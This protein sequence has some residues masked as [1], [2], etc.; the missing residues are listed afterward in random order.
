MLKCLFC[1]RYTIADYGGTWPCHIDFCQSLLAIE[2]Y[3]AF[4]NGITIKIKGL[5]TLL[6]VTL[7]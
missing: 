2:C 1:K 6:L 5:N 7:L 3:N 4:N